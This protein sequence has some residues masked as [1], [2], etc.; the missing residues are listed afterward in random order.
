VTYADTDTGKK[1]Y[2]RFGIFYE[3]AT[4]W[5]AGRGARTARAAPDV[6]V[7]RSGSAALHVDL[8]VHDRQR[9]LLDRHAAQR[10]HA[11]RREGRPLDVPTTS[12]TRTRGR[13]IMPSRRRGSRLRPCATACTAGRAR[14]KP[15]RTRRSSR[16]AASRPSL[17]A[18]VASM[19]PL[20]LDEGPR[21]APRSTLNEFFEIITSRTGSRRCSSPAANPSGGCRRPLKSASR[22]PGERVG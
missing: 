4:T 17:L 8:S 22:S 19:E 11:R 7:R 15:R 3:D 6:Q 10:D 20:G 13:R 9:R 2:T 14:R 5:R 18:L 1:P 21:R 12:T 16:S